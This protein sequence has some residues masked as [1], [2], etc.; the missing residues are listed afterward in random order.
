VYSRRV[1][2]LNPHWSAIAP[3]RQSERATLRLTVCGAFRGQ[4]D[5]TAETDR[6][7]VESTGRFAPA[8]PLTGV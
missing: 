3:I 5:A 8:I 7:T 4:I 6:R 1:I 2:L